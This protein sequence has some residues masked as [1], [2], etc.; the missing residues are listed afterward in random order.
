M[1]NEN[2]PFHLYGIYYINYMIKNSN[3]FKKKIAP[4]AKQDIPGRYESSSQEILQA[5]RLKR[6]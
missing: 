1:N 3:K 4:M 2:D 5:Q 6:P